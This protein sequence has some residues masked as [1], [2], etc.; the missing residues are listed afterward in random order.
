MRLR[1]AFAAPPSIPRIPVTGTARARARHVRPDGGTRRG[2]R[3]RGS[4]RGGSGVR[5]PLRGARASGGPRG[6]WPAAV[7]G[8]GTRLRTRAV[9]E[10]AWPGAGRQAARPGGRAQQLLRALSAPTVPPPDAGRPPARAG[11]PRLHCPR[12]DE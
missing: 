8:S 9:T 1:A 3:V 10:G 7:G 11:T 5:A 12:A 2:A 4:P 6:A